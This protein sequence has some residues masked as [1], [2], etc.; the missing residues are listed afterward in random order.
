MST[1]SVFRVTYHFEKNGKRCSDTF[2][3][4]VLAAS[5][6]FDALTAV[7]TNNGKTNN[8]I[9]SCVIESVGHVSAASNFLS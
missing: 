4:N 9:G 3:D 8:G 6:G 1:S 5:S 2:Q 7:L